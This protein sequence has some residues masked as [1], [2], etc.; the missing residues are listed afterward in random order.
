MTQKQVKVPMEST[1]GGLQAAQFDLKKKQ[2]QNKTKIEPPGHVTFE[3]SNTMSLSNELP[4]ISLRMS[5]MKKEKT[6]LL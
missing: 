3:K 1:R 5:I 4:T 2:K 6:K